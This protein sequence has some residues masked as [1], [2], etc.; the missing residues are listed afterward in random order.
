MKMLVRLS[1]AL[2]GLALL[3]A[4]AADVRSVPAFLF[5]QNFE[6]TRAAMSGGLSAELV[7]NRKFPGMPGRDGV[8]R[9]WSA[10]GTRAVY[11][12]QAGRGYVRHAARSAM[13][14]RNEINAQKITSLAAD[15]FAGIAQGGL[16]LQAGKKYRF[17]ANVRGEFDED[18]VDWR[19][20][21]VAADG[22]VVAEKS[23]VSQGRM[24][25]RFELIFTAEADADV[26]LKL[27]VVGRGSGAVGTVSLM[28]LDNFC[29]FRRDVVEALKS[30]GTSVV[31][32][33]GGNFAGDYRWL[34]G[35][36]PRDERA[37]IQS[38]M[39]IETQ[40]YTSGY[41]MNDIGTDEILALC[42]ELEAKPFFTVNLAWDS[43]KDSAEWVTYCKGAV[44]DWSLGSKFGYG[45][46]E[47]PNTPKEYAQLARAH[48]EAMKAA[49]R[50]I[51]LVASG[52]YPYQANPW[53]AES[54]KPLMDLAPCISAHVYTN[55]QFDCST[56]G[57][58]ARSVENAVAIVDKV[59]EHLQQ[60]RMQMPERMAIS[61]DEWNL[62]NAWYREDGGLQGVYAMKFLHRLMSDWQKLNLK[63]ACFFQAVNEGALRVEARSVR[64]TAQGEALRL[65]KGHIGG[66]P[67]PCE[68]PHA[69]GTETVPGEWFF[70]IYNPSSTDLCEVVLPVEAGAEVKEAEI[71][72]VGDPYPGTRYV[73]DS[74]DARRSADGKSYL[75]RIRPLSIGSI[76]F[77]EGGG[78]LEEK[79]MN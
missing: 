67:V 70:T 2:A 30:I 61:L 39:E 66:L 54:G 60:M 43:P 62:W 8:A 49:D 74:L 45:H 77:V 19:V 21:F 64:L 65:A 3:T 4:D 28:P 76:V 72:T 25:Y 42:R 52:L 5:G 73:R 12:L 9:E 34:D 35:T 6:P 50:S 27:G 40:P 41:D 23:C 68:S 47:G 79:G 26:Q 24:W 57:R 31:R 51:S 11:E 46:M 56:P 48:G 7:R 44:K 32:W 36:L 59:F 20:R 33:P 58:T 10:F 22:L 13:L 29:G 14:R 55:P 18:A 71:L 69:F 75:I 78:E 63:R 38:V 17:C 15:G 1:P 53:L 37:P 16:P